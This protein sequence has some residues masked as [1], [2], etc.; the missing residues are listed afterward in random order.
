MDDTMKIT[1]LIPADD[2]YVLYDWPGWDTLQEQPIAGFASYETLYEDSS[3]G[4]KVGIGAVVEDWSQG[5]C[6]I[7]MDVVSFDNARLHGVVAIYR[8]AGNHKLK[9]L[10]KKDLKKGACGTYMNK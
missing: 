9:T 3:M 1:N 5:N 8:G 10:A 6:G 2:W 4:I 7:D